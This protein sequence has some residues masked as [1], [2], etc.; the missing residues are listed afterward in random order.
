VRKLLLLGA[1]LLAACASPPLP[2]EKASPV[3]A[4]DQSLIAPPWEAMV[5]AGPDAEKDID[6]ETLNGP[7]AASAPEAPPQPELATVAAAPAEKP[8]PVK[9]PGATAINAVAVLPIAG[10]P[11]LSAALA[12]VLADAG[13]PV[14]KAARKDALS[15]QGRVTLDP[16]QAGQ[17]QVH[18]NWRV[19]TPQGKLL[20]DV[21][22][23][24]AIPAGSLDKGWGQSAM[25]AAQGGADGIVKLIQQYR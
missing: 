13:W 15:I 25:M 17:Q 19:S 4:P 18:I 14:L 5:Q 21:A 9:K 12:K 24:N 23:N 20:G 7:M 1:L 22:Q 2:F 10:A 16:A 6:L 11:E 3:A 8:A